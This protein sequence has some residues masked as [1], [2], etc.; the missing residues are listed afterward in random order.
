MISKPVRVLVADANPSGGEDLRSQL[1]QV[2]DVEVV[3]I[4]HS[5]PVAFN[6]DETTKP[7]IMLINQVICLSS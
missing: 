3:G 6:Q 5:Q 7:D 2:P 4:V 1:E